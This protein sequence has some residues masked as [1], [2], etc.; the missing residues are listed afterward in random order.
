MRNA[1]L[2]LLFQRHGERLKAMGISPKR[3]IKLMLDQSGPAAKDLF[4]AWEAIRISPLESARQ[5]AWQKHCTAWAQ[6]TPCP[7]PLCIKPPDPVCVSGLC[8]AP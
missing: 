1:N 7:V 3:A 6:K 2:T 5:A 8:Q 4:P